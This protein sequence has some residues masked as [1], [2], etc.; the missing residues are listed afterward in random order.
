MIHIIDDY[1]VDGS[2]KDF[3]LFKKSDNKN[4]DGEYVY[5]PL[6]YYSSVSSCVEAVRKIRCRELTANQ[7]ME[8]CEA[9]QAFK[10][11]AEELIEATKGLL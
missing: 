3:T 5:R 7:N 10:H 2:A 11:I 8:L 4:K 9:V 6:G 1:Y